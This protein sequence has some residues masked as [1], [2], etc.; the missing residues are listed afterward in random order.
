MAD[1]KHWDHLYAGITLAA[2]IKQHALR[3][4]AKRAA[5]DGL[6]WHMGAGVYRFVPAAGDTKRRGYGFVYVG[7]GA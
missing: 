5:E 4:P 7:E 6:E 1:R 3:G 2:F